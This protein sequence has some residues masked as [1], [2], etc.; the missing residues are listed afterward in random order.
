MANGIVT[1]GMMHSL[2]QRLARSL[3]RRVVVHRV[4]YVIRIPGGKSRTQLRY[5]IGI[6]GSHPPVFFNMTSNEVKARLAMLSDLLACGVIQRGSTSSDPEPY[7][8]AGPGRSAD[9]EPSGPHE[10]GLDDEREPSG[11]HD[12]Y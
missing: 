3:G 11:G 8:D 7:G 6:E 12:S 10:G 2:A 5:S 9:Q 4:E 1:T